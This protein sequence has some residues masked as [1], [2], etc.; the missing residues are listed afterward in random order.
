LNEPLICKLEQGIEFLGLLLSKNGIA[1]SEKK[2]LKL[3]SDIQS[4]KL[5]NGCFTKKSLETLSGIQRYYAQLLPQELLSPLDQTLKEKIASLILMDYKNIQSKKQLS[6]T[7]KTI[8][9]FSQSMELNKNQLINEW[10]TL[11]SEKKKTMNAD[12]NSKDQNKQLINQKKKEYRKKE[13]EA[14]E[15]V[16]SS[17]GSFIGKNNQGITVKIN[18]KSVKKTVSHALGHITVTSRA[19]SISSDAIHYCMENRIPVDFFDHSGKCYASILSPVSVEQSLWQKQTGMS[20]E[21]KAYLASRILLGKLKNQLHLIKYFH[22]YHKRGNMTLEECYNKTTAHLDELIEKMKGFRQGNNNYSEQLIAYEA[23]GATSY[24][25]Y[26][27]HLLMDDGVEFENRERYGATD[28]FNCM[29]NYGYALLYSRVWQA[30]LAAKLNPSVGVLHAY[31]QGKPTFVYDVIEIFRA[32]AVDRVIIGLVQKSEPLKM[33][34]NLLDEETRKL[35]VQ[36]VLER[37]NRYEKYRKAEIKFI[38]ILRQQL[39]EIAS[40][41]VGEKKTFKPYIAKW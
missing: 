19:V 2:K 3:Q 6:A 20:L 13:A 40:Y 33:D 38:D 35:I 24:W 17:F 25:E 22:K 26:I 29:L 16:I 4:I 31:Q 34:K 36:N 10:L 8:S 28:L 32:Q 15:L 11:Y 21:T 7:L 37:M 12:A 23:S 14:S 39:K 18:G 9:F 1:I 5:I 27:R 30:V 41:I